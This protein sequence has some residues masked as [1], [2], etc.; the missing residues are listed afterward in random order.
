V[1]L[2]PGAGPVWDWLAPVLLEV[3]FD[4][5]RVAEPV[6]ARDG[7]WTC[8]GWSATRWLTGRVPDESTAGWL[9]IVA[10]GRAF[11]RAIRGVPRPAC[12][13]ER[14]DPWALADRAAWG[15][16]ATRCLPEFAQ[17][18]PRLVPMLT[19]LGPSQLVHG[20]LTGNVLT[21]SGR[22]PVVID[23]S[24]YW[25]PPEYAEAIVVA[26]ALCWHGAS[27]ELLAAADTSVP[28]VARALLFRIGATS[29]RVH[30]GVPGL[31]VPDEAL[32]YE[33]AAA[34]LGL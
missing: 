5:V 24:P 18:V 14:A 15:D 13:D 20:D 25:R 26:D 12:L 21:S 8:L 22:L 29:E 2:K 6:A 28:V 9:E 11:H 31:D 7:S 33:H 19:P 1:V 27:V 23:V 34:V 32:R 17:V 30:A 16:G 3:P 4:D 10:A